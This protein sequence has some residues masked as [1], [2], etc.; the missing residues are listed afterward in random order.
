VSEP[1]ATA[2]PPVYSVSQVLAGLKGLLQDR[3]GRL[4]VSG[5]VSN[6]RVP[7]SGHAYFTL[8]D[9]AGQLRAVLFR[10]AARRLVFDPE[11]GLEVLAYG[12]LTVY[13]PRG[14][15][16]LIVQ[17][18]EP[19]GRGA[20]Q[21]AFEQLRAR[22]EGEGLFDAERKQELP[23]WPRVVGVVTSS[24]AAALRDVVHVVERRFPAQPL[25]LASSRV[26]GAGAEDELAAALQALDAQPDVEVILLVRGGGSLEDLQPFNTERLARAIAA[27]ATPVVSGVGHEVDVTIADLAADVRAATPS[28]AAAAAL[29]DRER[30][31]IR[32]DRDARRLVTAGRRAIERMR[33]RADAGAESLRLQAPRERLAARRGQLVAAG[34]AL[35]REI[36]ALLAARAA[37][38]AAAAGRLETL[39]PLGVVARG[40]AIVERAADGAIVRRAGDVAVG[41]GLRVRLAEGELDARVEAAREASPS[42]SRRS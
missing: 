37:G 27:C 18:L 42:G 33:N 32:L 1:S 19:R 3:V 21:L 38:M 31:A 30:V 5:E 20:L 6:L 41:D 2:G 10:G 28:A 4:W 25:L 14:D 34:R 8:K 16:Q 26:Q 9:D 7:A 17:E 36:Q 12:E 29:P 13:E 11:D 39:S 24:G 23:A 15:L 22:L 40:Y 35:R